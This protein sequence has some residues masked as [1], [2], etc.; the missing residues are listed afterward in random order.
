MSKHASSAPLWL[1][2][3]SDVFYWTTIYTLNVNCA[4]YFVPAISVKCFAYFMYQPRRGTD[5]G[6]QPTEL[7]PI[8]SVDITRR[9]VKYWKKKLS[10]LSS[11]LLLL[12]TC[13]S[14]TICTSNSHIA[15]FFW[16]LILF[17]V[18]VCVCLKLLILRNLFIPPMGA[19]L[20]SSTFFK[21][22]LPLVN[23]CFF[24]FIRMLTELRFTVIAV[25]WLVEAV[26]GRVQ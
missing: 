12:P 21:M 18:L 8:L 3:G 20:V 15:S 7:V 19:V 16:C 1:S 5:G 22:C 23:L 24:F 9:T 25:Y 14:L 17:V 2:P 26:S 4:P 11:C 10:I 6:L 13:Q